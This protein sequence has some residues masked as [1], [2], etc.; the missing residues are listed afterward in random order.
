M[1]VAVDGY[2]LEI[3]AFNFLVGSLTRI[4]LACRER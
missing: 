1:F 2:R 3:G 4:A